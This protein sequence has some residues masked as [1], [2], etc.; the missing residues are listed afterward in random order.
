MNVV[1]KGWQWNGDTRGEEEAK[2]AID[3]DPT[4]RVDPLQG[5]LGAV[6]V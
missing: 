6:E 5:N 4:S 2:Q 3:L 1:N